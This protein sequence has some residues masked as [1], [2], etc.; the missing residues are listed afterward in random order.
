MRRALIGAPVRGALDELI[1]VGEDEDPIDLGLFMR[2]HIFIYR[3]R[4]FDA[5][6]GQGAATA[7]DGRP[8]SSEE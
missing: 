1:R 5:D 6:R 3:R 2:N 7:R 4:R 8:K